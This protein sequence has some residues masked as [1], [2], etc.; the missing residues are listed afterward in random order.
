MYIS[1]AEENISWHCLFTFSLQVSPGAG[2]SG[3][4]HTPTSWQYTGTC[5]ILH[6][7]HDETKRGLSS[8]WHVQHVT[9]L[10][11]DM[12]SMWHMMHQDLA[13]SARDLFFMW[14][15]LHVGCSARDMFSTWHVQHVVHDDQ[16]ACSA[17]DMF[18]TFY[19]TQQ[20]GT[21][22]ALWCV[23]HITCSA[24]C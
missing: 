6:V 3:I 19:M 22:S 13:C 15:V 10:A 18:S 5:H 8:T 14:Y 2:K 17:R 23:Q 12:F 9:C 4:M 21:C 7:A 24:R 1:Y 20:C 16:N 11:C